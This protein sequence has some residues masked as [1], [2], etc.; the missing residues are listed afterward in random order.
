MAVGLAVAIKVGLG[1][2]VIVVGAV[3]VHPDVL[4]PVTV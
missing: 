3:F 2:T 1:T 4:V